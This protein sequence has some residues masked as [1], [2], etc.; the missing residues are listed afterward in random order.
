MIEGICQNIQNMYRVRSL[1]CN[2]AKT[3]LHSFTFMGKYDIML[4]LF[5][6]IKQL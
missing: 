6:G 4:K 5:Y 2:C 3:V 1:F